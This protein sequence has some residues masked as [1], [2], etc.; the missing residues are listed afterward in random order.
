MNTT[1]WATSVDWTK[2]SN[3]K[4]LVE[5]RRLRRMAEGDRGLIAFL[6]QSPPPVVRQEIAMLMARVERLVADADRLDP[7]GLTIGR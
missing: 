3:A 7:L 2:F 6:R 5:A 4:Q 1:D